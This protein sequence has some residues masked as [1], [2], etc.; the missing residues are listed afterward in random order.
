M[1]KRISTKVINLPSIARRIILVCLDIS[2]FIFAFYFSYWCTESFKN[3]SKYQSTE[4]LLLIIIFGILTYSNIGFYKGITRYFSSSSFYKLFIINLIFILPIYFISIGFYEDFISVKFWILFT[5]ILNFFIN[6]LRIFIRDILRK[7]HSIGTL[8]AKHIIIYGA[9]NAGA[10]LYSSIKSNPSYK[11]LFFVDDDK[12]LWN[13]TIN[14]IKIKSPKVLKDTNNL[15][16]ILLAI[17]SLSYSKRRKIITNIQILNIQLMQI[18]S[19]DD[20]SSGKAKYNQLKPICIEELLKRE[21]ASHDKKLLENFF[22]KKI[23]CV[24]GAGG[25]IGS[26]LCKQLIKLEPEKIILI[27]NHEP[28]LYKIH[29]K[30]KNIC[31]VNSINDKLIS[32]QLLSTTNINILNSIIEKEK[33]NFL[34]HAAAFK[35]VPIVECNPMAGLYNNVIST[36]NICE[37]SKKYNIEKVILISSDKAVRPTSIMGASKRLSELIFKNYDNKSTSTKFSMVR[38]GNVLNSSGS[39]VPLFQKQISEGGPITLTH[40]EIIRYFMTINE[41]ANL[42]IQVIS[43]AKGGDVYL[44]D[45]GKPVKIYDLAKQMVIQSGLNLKDKENPNGDIEI[46]ITG[47]REGEKLY[48]E[49]LIGNESKPTKNPLIFKDADPINIDR[50]FEEKLEEL[51]FNLLKGLSKESLDVLA[52]L[53][54]EW[55]KK[56]ITI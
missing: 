29:L 37:A 4:I 15:D 20:L 18:P 39:V 25:S 2:V 40:P 42:V 8:K 35:H 3:L 47:L 51:K 11:I 34:F 12:K 17:P 21:T 50:L 56:K 27:D 54:T 49:L 53:V 1:I 55:N 48:E 5:F 52:E 6:I 30:L 9:G 44:L 13:R 23:V 7:Y 46:K 43:M 26:E 32:T 45:M 22:K 41:A 38:F 19:L 33:V 36:I 31:K 16:L 28:S 10:N 14:G 24:T